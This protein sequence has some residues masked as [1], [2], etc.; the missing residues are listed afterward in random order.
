MEQLTEMFVICPY[1][2][3]SIEVLVDKEEAG[4]QYT[5]DCQVCCRPIIF[6][7]LVSIEG[8]LTV[9][10]YDENEPL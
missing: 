5:E 10:V 6:H 2:G 8:D 4:Q 3:E 7:I 1:C 9:S